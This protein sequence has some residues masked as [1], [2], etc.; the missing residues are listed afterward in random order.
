[1]NLG[2]GIKVEVNNDDKAWRKVVMPNCS[3][4]LPMM[5]TNNALMTR[6]EE[7]L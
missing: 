7:Y 2:D 6:Y 4:C 1:M 3:A 5:R